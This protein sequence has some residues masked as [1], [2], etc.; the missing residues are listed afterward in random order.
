MPTRSLDRFFLWTVLIIR[1]GCA[2]P[3]PTTAPTDVGATYSPPPG[4]GPVTI[5]GI[6]YAYVVMP[7]RE[8]EIVE[9]FRK[10]EVGQCREEVRQEMG[11]PDSAETMYGMAKDSPFHGWSYMYKIRMR[12]GGPN[13]NDVCVE[14]FFNPEGKLRRAVPNPIP[15]LGDV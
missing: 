2:A 14:V 12:P 15:A 5:E 9:G 11:P 13:T 10:L 7:A 1:G 8:Q 4:S 3:S 6:S